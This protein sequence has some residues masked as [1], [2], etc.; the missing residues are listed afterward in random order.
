MDDAGHLRG[1]Q[2]AAR[3]QVH[4]HRRGRRLVVAQKRGALGHCQMHPRAGHRADGLDGAR[5]LAFE[6]A[7]I[8]DL[9]VKL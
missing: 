9:L 8:V 6:T 7:L 2:I 4:E 1:V 3:V 5:Q